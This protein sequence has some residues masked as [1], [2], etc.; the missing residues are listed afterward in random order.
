MTKYQRDRTEFLQLR[1]SPQKKA[2]IRA[3]AQDQGLTI[4]AWLERQADE[5]LARPRLI[6]QDR[7]AAVPVQGALDLSAADGA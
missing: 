3:A 6:E 2:E 5:A 7:A 4:T 1:L